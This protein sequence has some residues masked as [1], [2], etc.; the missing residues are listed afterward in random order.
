MKKIVLILIS[1]I[2][3][4][5]GGYLYYKNC[6]TEKIQNE[7]VLKMRTH[8]YEMSFLEYSYIDEFDN[9][10]TKKVFILESEIKL[11][12]IKH[13]EFCVTREGYNQKS[14]VIQ[15]FKDNVILKEYTITGVVELFKTELK[16]Q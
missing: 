3:L 6:Y 1:L 5:I 4:T 11:N 12:N 8:Y 14:T 7:I 13:L 9:K 16:F 10:T 2:I 15:I